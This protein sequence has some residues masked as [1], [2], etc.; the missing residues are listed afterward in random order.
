MQAKDIMSRDFT[1]ISVDSSIRHAIDL[2]VTNRISGLPVVDDAG[3]VVGVLTEG[4]LMRRAELG[5]GRGADAPSTVDF[6][7][8]VRG[9]S[10]HVRDLMSADPISVRPDTPLARVAEIMASRGVKRLPV[11]DGD[12]LVGIVSRSDV[13]RSILNAPLDRIAIGDEAMAR[14]AQ[15]R[16]LGDLGIGSDRVSVS[17]SLGTLTAT[18]TVGSEAERKA[19][20]VLLENIGGVIGYRDLLEPLAN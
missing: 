10:W 14:A 16:L 17:A 13:L 12:R 18:G 2:M 9:N 15:A 3:H 6:E 11:M 1:T 20:R 19:I 7:A 5:G 4:D 8:Y